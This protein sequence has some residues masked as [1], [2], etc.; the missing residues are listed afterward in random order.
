MNTKSGKW[1][2]T[3]SISKKFLI[4]IQYNNNWVLPPPEFPLLS[5]DFVWF[6]NTNTRFQNLSKE[7]VAWCRITTF[8]WPILVAVAWI[9]AIWGGGDFSLTPRSVVSLAVWQVLLK[10]YVYKIHSGTGNWDY[11]KPFHRDSVT[12]SDLFQTVK[13]LDT[14]LAKNSRWSV[15][16]FRG[17]VSYKLF[18][19]FFG[20]LN[21]TDLLV[22]LK[23]I[24]KHSSQ[25][26][27]SH[28]LACN[29]DSTN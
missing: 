22:Q 2:P 9:V 23:F 3:L 20:L 5:Q 6:V 19:V 28:F 21:L 13:S 12:L 18:E 1:D 16:Y 14:P 26:I 15:I 27:V 24:A 11:E 10:P 8:W 17:E 7:E 25:I 4:S 29:I